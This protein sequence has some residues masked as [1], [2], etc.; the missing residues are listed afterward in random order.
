MINSYFVNCTEQTYF[1]EHSLFIFHCFLLLPTSLRIYPFFLFISF[2]IHGPRS[3]FI[4]DSRFKSFQQIRTNWAFLPIYDK[5]RV[6][7]TIWFRINIAMFK[8]YQQNSDVLTFKAW[9]KQL[10]G[11]LHN[12]LSI[13]LSIQPLQSSIYLSSL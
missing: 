4:Q 2:I 1:R 13:Y 5:P 12:T 7:F 10:E 8:D 11:G 3:R 9:C 6:N